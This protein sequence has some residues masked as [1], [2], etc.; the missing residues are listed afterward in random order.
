MQRPH[1]GAESKGH[2]AI[3]ASRPSHHPYL[4]F[5][6]QKRWQTSWKWDKP[7][8]CTVTEFQ[9]HS[10]Q[11]RDKT[12]SCYCI[13]DDLSPSKDP[14]GIPC[15]SHMSSLSGAP[16]CARIYAGHYGHGDYDP[17]PAH[18]AGRDTWT[19]VLAYHVEGWPWRQNPALWEHRAWGEEDRGVGWSPSDGEDPRRYLKE[20]PLSWLC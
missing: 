9:A 16:P 15:L 6:S 1:V 13:C 4:N 7:S 18:L 3:P 2:L 14:A 8:Y 5:A 17:I 10:V 11:E 19:D 12:V 20:M